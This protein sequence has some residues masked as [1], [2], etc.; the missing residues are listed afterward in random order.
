MTW[1]YGEDDIESGTDDVKIRGKK[2]KME[3]KAICTLCLP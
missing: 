2:N 3:I 1:D